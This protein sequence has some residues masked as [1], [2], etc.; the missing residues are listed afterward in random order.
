MPGDAAV[1][2]QQDVGSSQPV[3]RP[4]PPLQLVAPPLL[5][6]IGI[7][8]F[9]WKGNPLGHRNSVA[10]GRRV[11]HEFSAVRPAEPELA[12][13]EDADAGSVGGAHLM[14]I[15]AATPRDAVVR[16]LLGYSPKTADHT[17]GDLPYC[18]ARRRPKMRR[19]RWSCFSGART[20]F[21]AERYQAANELEFRS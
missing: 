7:D 20:H 11:K 19:R 15:A 18:G 9:A 21:P 14:T 12:T 5:T 2:R 1:M 16:G 13:L 17:A 4:V 8:L 6:Y 3:E 10:S